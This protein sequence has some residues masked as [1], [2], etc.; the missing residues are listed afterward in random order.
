MIFSGSKIVQLIN[1]ISRNKTIQLFPSIVTLPA[2]SFLAELRLEISQISLINTVNCN[3][4]FYVKIPMII[5]I[6]III[7]II[8]IIITE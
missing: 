6:A 7:V 8:T 2:N 5:I 3:L 1:R 4:Y